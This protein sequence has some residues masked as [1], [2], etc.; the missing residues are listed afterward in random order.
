M[1]GEEVR[2]MS[3]EDLKTRLKNMRME[4][5]KLRQKHVTE[6]VQKVHEFSE[7]RSDIARLLT[8]MNARRHKANPKKAA[9][10]AVKPVAK[11]APKKTV[12]A[13]ARVTKKAPVKG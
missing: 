3:A 11:A 2:K 5:F 4:L 13:P 12:K 1:T 9:A 10:P 7:M 6:K 8:E